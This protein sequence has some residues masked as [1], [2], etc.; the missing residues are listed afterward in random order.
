MEPPRVVTEQQNQDENPVLWILNPG[1][2][3]PLL[4]GGGHSLLKNVCVLARTQ[5][6][7]LM[8]VQL[9][10]MAAGGR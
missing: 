5:L 3:T 2:S 7:Y 8:C 4:L 1:L 9:R 6:Y 10:G